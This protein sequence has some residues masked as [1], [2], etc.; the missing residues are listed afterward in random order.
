[1]NH[2][3]LEVNKII[4]LIACVKEKLTHSAPAIEM[5]IGEE[6]KLWVADALAKKVDAIYIL[7]GKYGLL[8]P[9]EIIEP[10]D[11]NLN[12]TS[13]DERKIWALKVID[14]LKEFEELTSV[15]ASLYC[16]ERY[17]EFLLE[18]LPHHS[19]VCRID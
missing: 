10:Y 18:Q 11:V 1:M 9:D 17:A 19:F 2:K 7:S 12:K 8:L 15:Q 5:Y 4:A 14:R 3:I 13:D 16:N 6:F